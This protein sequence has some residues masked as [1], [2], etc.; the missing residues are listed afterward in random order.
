LPCTSRRRRRTRRDASDIDRRGWSTQDLAEIEASDAV[1]FLV[2]TPPETTRG[3]WYE[4]GYADSEKKHLV[5]SGDTRQSVFCARGIEFET[6]AGALV[7]L[8]KLRA[9]RERVETGL[10]ELVATAPDYPSAHQF[11]VGGAE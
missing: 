10:A 3:A 9:D 5:F 1:W 7:Y 4:A 2:P 11:D 6:D 8:R